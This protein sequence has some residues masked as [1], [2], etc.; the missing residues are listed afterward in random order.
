MRTKRKNLY[1]LLRNA[2][3]QKSIVFDCVKK[4]NTQ[5]S[6]CVVFPG[7]C[8][9]CISLP[10]ASGLQWLK[11]DVYRDQRDPGEFSTPT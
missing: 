3:E 5:A 8:M 9:G 6:S 7:A 4:N 2:I 10:G 1:F 11:R